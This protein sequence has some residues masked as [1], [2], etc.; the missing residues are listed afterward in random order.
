M[1][2]DIFYSHIYFIVG[3]FFN[4]ISMVCTC[5]APSMHISLWPYDKDVGVEEQSIMYIGYYSVF[6]YTNEFCTCHIMT[7]L[8]I[9]RQ[10]IVLPSR[11]TEIQPPAAYA[12]MN[13]SSLRVLPLRCVLALAW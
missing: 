5:V 12:P 8:T 4:D 7:Y 1:C 9:R 10:A 3:D 13:S 2:K 6:K 11:E